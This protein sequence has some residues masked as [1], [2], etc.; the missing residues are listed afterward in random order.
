V[1]FVRATKVAP[2]L[3]VAITM[4]EPYRRHKSQMVTCEL[5]LGYSL[6]VKDI[7]LYPFDK[8]FRQTLHNQA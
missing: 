3:F 4:T 2:V 1:E 7:F 6:P 5:A 8:H